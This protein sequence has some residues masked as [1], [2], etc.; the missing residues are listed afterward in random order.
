[1]NILPAL[2]NKLQQE[3]DVAMTDVPTSDFHFMMSRNG[4]TISG[5][6]PAFITVLRIELTNDSYLMVA[7]AD[8]L[9]QLRLHVSQIS[10]STYNRTTTI[11]PIDIYTNDFFEQLL[12][13]IRIYRYL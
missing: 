5:L 3:F 7:Q 9:L 4:S 13:T 12:R 10:G 8:N 11:A 2:R 1:M 6:V